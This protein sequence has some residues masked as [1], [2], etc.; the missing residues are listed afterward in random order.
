[1]RKM[2]AKLV[3]YVG[4]GDFDEVCE[5]LKEVSARVKRVRQEHMQRE[6][7]DLAARSGQHA[8]GRDSPTC[9]S[10]GCC[11]KA[12]DGGRNADSSTAHERTGTRKCAGGG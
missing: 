11:I 9:T 5:D 7:A 2:R 4:E 3:E 6:K 8:D 12:T 10:Y 1:M